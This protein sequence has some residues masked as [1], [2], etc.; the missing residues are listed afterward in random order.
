ME[1]QKRI[2]EVNGIK[3]EIDLRTAKRVDEFKVGDAVK[4]LAKDY[5]SYKSYPG[6]IVGFDQFKLRPT[7]IVAYI[8]KDYASTKLEFAYIN[9]ETPDFEIAPIQ[10]FETKVSWREIQE[11]FDKKIKDKAMEVE[12]LKAEKEWFNGSYEKWF[13]KHFGDFGASVSET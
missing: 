6:V 5:Q 3:M 9:S 8:K 2:I 11:D 1:E 10:E 13:G 7:I 4:L 12:K